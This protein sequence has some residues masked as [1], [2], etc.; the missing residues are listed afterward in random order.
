MGFK[1]I[2]DSSGNPIPIR[3]VPTGLYRLTVDWGRGLTI[4]ADHMKVDAQLRNSI[5]IKCAGMDTLRFE[6]DKD[7]NQ[8]VNEY[9]AKVKSIRRSPKNRVFEQRCNERA[10]YPEGSYL[11]TINTL[12]PMKRHIDIKAG[13]ETAVVIPSMGTLA[14]NVADGID[15][16]VYLHEMEAT[17]KVLCTVNVTIARTLTLIPGVYY[18]EY[19]MPNSNVAREFKLRINSGDTTSLNLRTY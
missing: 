9:M 11:V 19:R 3:N 13:C 6:Y 8:P 18:L 17:P 16:L 4:E 2:V 5:Y 12:P 10:A 14:F 1:R 7:K 15:S